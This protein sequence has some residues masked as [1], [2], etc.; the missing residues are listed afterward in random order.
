[1]EHPEQANPRRQKAG[2]CQGLG[3]EAMGSNCLVG[4]RFPLGVTKKFWN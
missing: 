2:G 3:E 4:V 1:M